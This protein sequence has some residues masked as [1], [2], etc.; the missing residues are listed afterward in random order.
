MFST[1]YISAAVIILGQ[2]LKFLGIEVASEELTN[3]VTTLGTI[4]LG[5]WILWRRYTK[6]D[7][8]V[9]GTKKA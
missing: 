5:L 9:A 2:I 8:T 1:T 4:L 7:I 3:A 6:G